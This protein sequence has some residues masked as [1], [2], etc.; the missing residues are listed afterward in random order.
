M[1]LAQHHGLPTRLL[2]WTLSPF[3]ALHFLTAQSQYSTVAGAIW[4]VDIFA[5]KEYL[6]PPLKTILDRE[7]T[8]TFTAAMLDQGAATL[9]QF[10]ALSESPFLAFLEP[11]SL[12][13]RI[14]NQ[15]A[16]FSIMPSPLSRPDEWLQSHPELSTRIIVSPELKMEIRDKLDQLNITE[17]M[18]FPGLDGLSAW[19]RRH[20]GH[21]SLV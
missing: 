18:L 8:P 2:D 15:Y 17:R 1:A 21:G 12:D 5:A 16:L 11:P 7:G 13:A 6:P 3:V 19:L 20:C 10:E 4:R 14:I 9:E